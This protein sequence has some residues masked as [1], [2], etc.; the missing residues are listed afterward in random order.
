MA[1]DVTLTNET[2][3]FNYDRGRVF[4]VDAMDDEET[5]GIAFGRL[6]GEFV[7]TKWHRKWMRSAL[8]RMRLTAALRKSGGF[9]RWRRR[10]DGVD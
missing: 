8:R 6:A 7:R 5:A 3:S 2:V 10:I 1:G 4:T 9:N